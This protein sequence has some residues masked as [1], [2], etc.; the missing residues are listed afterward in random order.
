MKIFNIY[1]HVIKEEEVTHSVEAC[2]SQFGRELFGDE[3][4]GKERNTAHENSIVDMLKAFTDNEYGEETNS[5]LKVAVKK[6][7][8]CMSVYPDVLI[9]DNI[10]A[11]RGETIPFKY[12]Y[13]NYKQINENG[14][15]PYIYKAKSVIQSWTENLAIGTKYANKNIDDSTIEQVL[16]GIVFETYDEASDEG[17]IKWLKH[18]LDYFNFLPYDIGVLI[19]HIASPD[20]FLF[21]AKYFNKLSTFDNEDEVLRITN[22]PLQ[23][24]ASVNPAFYKLVHELNKYSKQLDITNDDFKL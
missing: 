12:L 19:E 10:P 15:F 16:E 3:L 14:S 6:L 23:C 1:E 11:Y 8:A 20:S 17:K 13:K 5:K 24:V 7:K 4:G 21:K 18:K 2:V 9:P 22:D